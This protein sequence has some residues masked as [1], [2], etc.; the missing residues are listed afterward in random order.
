MKSISSKNESAEDLQRTRKILLMTQQQLAD[1]LGIPVNTL[2]RW[3]RGEL[4]IQHPIVLKLALR[5]IGFSVGISLLTEIP[6]Y[7]KK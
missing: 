2:A 6:R 1:A 7:V 3:E 4:R 5:A